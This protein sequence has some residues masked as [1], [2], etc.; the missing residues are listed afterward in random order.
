MFLKLKRNN[1]PSLFDKNS[2]F[3]AQ[4]TTNVDIKSYSLPQKLRKHGSQDY[5]PWGK[6]LQF[7]FSVLN[8][9]FRVTNHHI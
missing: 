9:Q 6:T 8:N 4:I 1:L 5:I 7:R 2:R 3:V